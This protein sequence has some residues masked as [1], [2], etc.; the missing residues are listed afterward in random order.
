[1]T[2]RR[3]IIGV[4]IMLMVIPLLTYNETDYGL[5]FGLRKIFW[6]GISSCTGDSYFCKQSPELVTVTGWY[7][8]LE[9]YEQNSK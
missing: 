5:I 4:L 8:L 1:M 6:F 9:Q 2:T 7:K 3:V